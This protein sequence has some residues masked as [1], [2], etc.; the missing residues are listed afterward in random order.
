MLRMRTEHL[1]ASPELAPAD[2]GVTVVVTVPNHV[3]NFAAGGEVT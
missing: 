3:K 2:T 1:C